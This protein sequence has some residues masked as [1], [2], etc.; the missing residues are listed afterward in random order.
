MQ[1]IDNQQL[2]TMTGGI[3]YYYP[4]PACHAPPGA[5]AFYGPYPAYAAPY[6]A[7]RAAWWPQ[8]AAYNQYAGWYGPPAPARRAWWW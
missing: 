7:P 2:A 8:Y 3:A 6:A 4:A 5:R 1:T